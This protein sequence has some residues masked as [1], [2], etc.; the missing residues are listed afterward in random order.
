MDVFTPERRSEIMR[1]I[2]GTDTQP[3]LRVRRVLHSM[4]VRFRLHRG[5]LPGNT[6]IFVHG[7]FWHGHGCK[8]GSG[9]RRP[10]SNAAYWNKKLDRNA[11]RDAGNAAKLRRLGWRVVTI[12]ACETTDEARLAKR[13]GAALRRTESSRC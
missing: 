2:K 4:G 6:V 5:G 13:L 8:R 7:C 11:E 12:W 10:K 1:R 9:K 3:E